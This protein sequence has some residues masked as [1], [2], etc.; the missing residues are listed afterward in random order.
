MYSYWNII[1][2]LL[3]DSS[4]HI[5]IVFFVEGPNRIRCCRIT[6]LTPADSLRCGRGK[7]MAVLWEDQTCDGVGL[8][9]VQP[10]GPK[11][12]HAKMPSKAG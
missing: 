5:T 9:G 2:L 6:R 1:G 7:R 3:D 11:G 8:C 12:H 10:K 4:I